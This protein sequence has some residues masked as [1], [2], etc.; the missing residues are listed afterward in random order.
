MSPVTSQHFPS[1]TLESLLYV[2]FKPGL[3]VSAGIDID[4]V[5]S[6]GLDGCSS[7]QGALQGVA[8]CSLKQEFPGVT[9]PGGVE[10]VGG[11]NLEGR[12]DENFAS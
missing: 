8:F 4:S 1:L 2:R 3:F 10:K 12:N 6:G 9:L 5:V 11:G 7:L